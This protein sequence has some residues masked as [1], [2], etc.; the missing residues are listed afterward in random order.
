MFEKHSPG[1]VRKMIG[2]YGSTSLGRGG[3]H[4][5]LL[6]SPPKH[7][8]QKM[9][10]DLDGGAEMALRSQGKVALLSQQPPIGPAKQEC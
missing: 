1:S 6:H 8:L 2:I 9:K 3:L 10:L 7:F 5:S 4:C